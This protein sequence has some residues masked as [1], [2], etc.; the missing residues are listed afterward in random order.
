[1]PVSA[2]H[3]QA[4]DQYAQQVGRLSSWARGLSRAQLSAAPTG[5]FAGTWTVGQNIVHCLDSDLAA[6]HRMRRIVAEATPLLIAYDETQF[7]ASLSYEHDDIELVCRLF[8]DNRRWTAAWLSRLPDDAFD[9]AG[10]H[11]QR[12]RVTLGQFVKIYID[13][14]NHHDKFVAAKREMLLSRS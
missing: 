9:R 12:G 10:I 4:V 11:N 1:M 8:D 3:A 2:A 5:Q 7:A 6:T 14:I 13:H